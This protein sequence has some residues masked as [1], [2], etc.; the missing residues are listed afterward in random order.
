MGH[1]RALIAMDD[2]EAQVAL[3]EEAIE[4]DLSVRE[5][6]TRVRDWHEAG[7]DDTEALDPVDAA[8][9]GSVTEPVPDRSDLQLEELRSKLRSQFST[10]VQ[11]QHTK[12][13]EGTIEIAYYSEE[14]L[15]RI[16]EMMMEG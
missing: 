2:T 7:A 6:E 11:I 10:Q 5:V 1:A 9:E 14:D 13:G 12:D 16:V 8:E 3:L 15:A 4:E